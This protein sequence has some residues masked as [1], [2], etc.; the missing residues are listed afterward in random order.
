[1][2]GLERRVFIAAA[3]YNVT[4][5]TLSY[6]HLHL[7]GA[8]DTWLVGSQISTSKWSAMGPPPWPLCLTF[9]LVNMV[10]DSKGA[11]VKTWAK[12][13]IGLHLMCMRKNID[14][15]KEA[16]FCRRVSVLVFSFSPVFV[17]S[18]VRV[19]VWVCV[20]VCAGFVCVCAWWDAQR[21]ALCKA[22][23]RLS[24]HGANCHQKQGWEI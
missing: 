4:T 9:E 22:S 18:C 21:C 12:T 6:H 16:C 3:V 10:F 15:A 5:K 20:C 17:C 19:C 7:A 23:S 11:R 8:V 1:M 14:A 2:F 13:T 24:G